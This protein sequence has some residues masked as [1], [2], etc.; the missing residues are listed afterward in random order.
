[1]HFLIQTHSNPS[2]NRAPILSSFLQ[3]KFTPFSQKRTPSPTL[4]SRAQVGQT[5]KVVAP[6]LYLGVGVSGAIQHMAGGCT[7]STIERFQSSTWQVGA[8]T[9]QLNGFINGSFVGTPISKDA[10]RNGDLLSCSS[11]TFMPGTSIGD[12]M[13]MSIRFYLMCVQASR[14]WALQNQRN[15]RT[16]QTHCKC[17]HNSARARSLLAF[18]SSA[19]REGSSQTSH[20]Y[21]Q[22]HTFIYTD[23]HSRILYARGNVC[24]GI[25]DSRTIAAI[26]SDS[27]CPMVKVRFPTVLHKVL[28]I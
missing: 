7:Y 23:V 18:F 14:V 21:V 4:R 20:I 2:I 24:A 3:T 16:A 22:T 6:D 26:N 9:K 27:E 1:M 25:K 10:Q 13:Q 19:V 8:H 11:I 12:R 28:F 15:Q 5:G 17:L